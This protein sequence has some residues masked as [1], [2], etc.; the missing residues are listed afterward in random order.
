MIND[1]KILA[2][3]KII[4]NNRGRCSKWPKFLSY[5]LWPL[6]VLR[7]SFKS[8]LSGLAKQLR[9]WNYDHITLFFMC[10]SSSESRLFIVNMLRQ[11]HSSP[12]P[13]SVHIDSQTHLTLRYFCFNKHTCSHVL[14]IVHHFF[15]LKPASTTDIFPFFLIVKGVH[16]SHLIVKGVGTQNSISALSNCSRLRNVFPLI[17]TYKSCNS[18]RNLSVP[19]IA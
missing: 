15:P 3:N 19:L 11:P 12:S 14:N 10:T 1:N 5:L 4:A 16:H 7:S 17:Y 2:N 9:L 13:S 18:D 6:A 8:H